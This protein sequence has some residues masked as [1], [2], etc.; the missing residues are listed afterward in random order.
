L[1]QIQAH[2]KASISLANSVPQLPRPLASYSVLLAHV[3]EEP[4]LQEAEMVLG[5]QVQA[6]WTAPVSPETLDALGWQALAARAINLETLAT[7]QVQSST[8]RKN[9]LD[10][11][12]LPSHRTPS[13]PSPP[14]VAQLSGIL[15]SCA[16]LL[17]HVETES[18]LQ[19]KSMVLGF[20]SSDR[21]APVSHA[22]P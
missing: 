1:G 11:G 14:L 3:E 22:H 18:L 2:W 6:H 7:E 10:V 17:A 13:L 20:A 12:A 19:T 16:F 9:P 15:A 8:S 5:R 21:A 4:L